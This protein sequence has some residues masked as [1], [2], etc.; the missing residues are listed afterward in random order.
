MDLLRPLPSFL[1]VP[2]SVGASRIALITAGCLTLAAC[3]VSAPFSP[4]PKLPPRPASGSVA[5]PAV[6]DRPV[7]VPLDAPPPTPPDVGTRRHRQYFDQK[8]RRF[9]YFDPVLKRYFWEDGTPR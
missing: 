2:T 6:S 4:A 1:P 8:R 3:G 9:Y 5:P 7:A